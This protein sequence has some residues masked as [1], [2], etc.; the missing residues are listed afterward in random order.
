[1]HPVIVMPPDRSQVVAGLDQIGAGQRVYAQPVPIN[2]GRR[3]VPAVIGRLGRAVQPKPPHEAR[4]NVPRTPVVAP[5]IRTMEDVVRTQDNGADAQRCHLKLAHKR[6]PQVGECLFHPDVMRRT[7]VNDVVF[8]VWGVGSSDRLIFHVLNHVVEINMVRPC[9]IV[10][11]LFVIERP[12]V[13][14]GRDRRRSHVIGDRLR[15]VQYLDLHGVVVT[16]FSAVRGAVVVLVP[17]LIFAV[18]GEG[19]GG[20]RNDCPVLATSRLHAATTPGAL[21]ISSTSGT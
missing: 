12:V 11:I 18:A 4:A 6:P 7:A 13:R 10:L 15:I 21:S 2:F 8:V 17:N 3:S 14:I 16:L 9:E 1:M 19:H 20:K 5:V